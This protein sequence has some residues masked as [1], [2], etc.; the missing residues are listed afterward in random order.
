MSSSHDRLQLSQRKLA[1]FMFEISEA[2]YSA[3][4]M[5]N[6]E[7]SLWRA[8]VEGPFCY[9][10]L[11]IREDQ[12]ATLRRLSEEC[13]GWIC[14]DGNGDEYFMPIRDWVS[15]GYDRNSAGD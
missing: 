8:V 10:R 14:L 5:V 3:G 13:G 2:A 4:W 6:L 1:E 15:Q 9:G 7:H 11:H 12:I